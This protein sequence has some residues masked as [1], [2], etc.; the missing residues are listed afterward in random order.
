M[1]PL[2]QLNL[3]VWLAWAPQG[4]FVRQGFELEAI[5]PTLALDLALQRKLHRAGWKKSAVAPDLLLRHTAEGRWRLLECKQSSFGADSS[6]AAQAAALLVLTPRWFAQARA[7]LANQVAQVEVC[8]ALNAGHEEAQQAALEELRQRVQSLGVAANPAGAFGMYQEAATLLL[9]GAP[10]APCA[11]P[12]QKVDLP[13]EGVYPLLPVDP[14]IDAK[15]PA[16]WEDLQERL[17]SGLVAWMGKHLPQAVAQPVA[18]HLEDDLLRR[19]IL[20]WE[21]WEDAGRKAVRRRARAFV[22]TLLKPLRKHFTLYEEAPSG[23]VW[24]FQVADQAAAEAITKGLIA[25]AARR[26]GL[27][28]SAPPQPSL[29]EV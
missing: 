5:G 29:F 12:P 19:V 21:V 16:A 22:R 17:R 24:H 3:M 10:Q 8:Y 15:D 9:K 4:W 1:N 26:R 20:V 7:I 23:Q 28:G 14:S 27:D 11:H 18:L 13:P 2:E 25:A 6:T